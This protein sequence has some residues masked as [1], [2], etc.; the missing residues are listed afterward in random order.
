MK[1][2]MSVLGAIKAEDLGLTLSHEHLF[3]NLSCLW[4][5]PIDPR[6]AF[7]VDAPVEAETRGLLMSDPYHCRAN[8]VLDDE[9]LAVLELLRFKDIGG[10]TILDLSTQSIGP[11]PEKLKKVA[12]KTGVNIIAGTGFYTKRAHPGHVAT[13]SVDQLAREMIDDLTV[14]FKK[15]GIKAG[16]I[17]EIGS[18][19]PLHSDELKVLKAAAIAHKET[20]VGINIHLAIFAREGHNVLDIFESASVPLN[21]ICLS[22]VDESADPEYQLSLARRGCFVEFDCFGSEVYFDEDQLREPSDAE[23]VEALIALVVAGF[24]DQI[25]VSQD[26]CTRMQLRQFG[27]MGY[28]H[29]LRTIVPR[30]LHRGIEQSVLDKFLIHNPRRFLC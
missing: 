26:V 10:R 27:G 15:S 18:S 22:H 4:H 7:L 16:L 19:S 30:L 14:G 20:G 8:L 9:D 12:E 17:G 3:I 13:A 21:K 25:L 23:R 2:A 28:D 24:E 11:F 1:E 5:E 29:F 6:R